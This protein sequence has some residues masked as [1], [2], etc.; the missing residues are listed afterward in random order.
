MFDTIDRDKQRKLMKAIDEVN[1]K[2]GHNAIRIVS[3]GYSKNWHLKNEHLS[4]PY[5]INLEEVI[6]VKV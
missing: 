6:R 4:R 1:K 5:T 3:Q 2:N